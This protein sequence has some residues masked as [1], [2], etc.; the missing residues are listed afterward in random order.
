M[1]HDPNAPE[2]KPE[3]PPARLMAAVAVI[4]AIGLA[5]GVTYL[6]NRIGY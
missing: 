5:A 1:P 2:P 3:S 4:A 6:L